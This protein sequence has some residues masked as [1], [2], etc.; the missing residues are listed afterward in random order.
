[1]VIVALLVAWAVVACGLALVLARAL[2]VS[3]KSD[4]WIHG[5]RE[6]R[7][8]RRLHAARPATLHHAAHRDAA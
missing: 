6:M 2:A 4:R 3:S 7:D 1:M 8:L 5:H